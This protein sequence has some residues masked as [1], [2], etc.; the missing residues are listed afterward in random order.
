MM[1]FELRKNPTNPEQNNLSTTKFVDFERSYVKSVQ[2]ESTPLRRKT[3][4]LRQ[5][6]IT[7]SLADISGNLKRITLDNLQ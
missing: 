4:L 7:V 5:K 2:A 1:H 6:F 3:I